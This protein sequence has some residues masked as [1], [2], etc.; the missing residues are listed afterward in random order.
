MPVLNGPGAVAQVRKLGCTSFIV[1]VTGNVLVED[2]DYFKACGAN[3]VFPKPLQ[4]PSLEA[5]W[6]EYGVLTP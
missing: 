6:V 2:V 4:L 1:G 3:S 5:L